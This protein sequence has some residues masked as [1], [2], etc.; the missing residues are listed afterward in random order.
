MFFFKT[1]FIMQ[2]PPPI[3]FIYCAE[4]NIFFGKLCNP[5]VAFLFSFWASI[6][7][8]GGGAQMCALGMCYRGGIVALKK[9]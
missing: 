4:W 5:R 8:G 7:V 2:T 6:W 9:Y 1:H 3:S